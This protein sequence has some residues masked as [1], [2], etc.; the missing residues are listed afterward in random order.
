MMVK[1]VLVITAICILAGLG[2]MPVAAQAPTDTPTPTITN[3]PTETP[4][5]TPTF[6]PTFDLYQ[7]ATLSSGQAVAVVYEIR[8]A[9]AA[10]VVLLGI[11]NGLV[12][13]GLILLLRIS[14]NANN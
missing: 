2:L 10:Q 12:V 5:P 11:L 8:P 13:F 4:T 1:A 9:N 14:R 3:T 7:Y 6:T